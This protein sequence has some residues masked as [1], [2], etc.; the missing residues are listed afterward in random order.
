[1][2]R[3]G[4]T[5]QFLVAIFMMGALLLNYPILYLFAAPGYVGGV[6]LLYAYVFGV[7]ILLI[8]LM[9]GVIERPRD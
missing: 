8:G 3:T 2:K 9:A 6:P 7:W 1:M 4:K 5:G